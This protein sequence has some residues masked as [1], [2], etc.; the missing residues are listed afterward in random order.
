M[1]VKNQH[2]VARLD[3]TNDSEVQISGISKLSKKQIMGALCA[4]LLYA[5]R[6]DLNKDPIEFCK[7][8]LARCEEHDNAQKGDA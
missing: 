4:G 8:V 1:E 3:I 5:I 6:T 7:E 2:I